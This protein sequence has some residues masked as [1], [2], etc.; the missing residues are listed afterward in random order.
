M[1]Y[2]LISKQRCALV[3]SINISRKLLEV[4]MV[5][6]IRINLVHK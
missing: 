3:L 4:M 1:L 2:D 5:K 6:G